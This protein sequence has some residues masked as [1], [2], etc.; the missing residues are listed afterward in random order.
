MKKNFFLLSLLTNQNEQNA[1]LE[2]TNL[3]KHPLFSNCSSRFVDLSFFLNACLRD[4]CADQSA[5]H[6]DEVKCSIVTALTHICAGK[7]FFID[8]L[9]D[10]TLAKSCRT[11]NYGECPSSSDATY[12][13]C[14]SE[15]RSSC[16]DFDVV[17]SSC[18]E[19]CLPGKENNDEFCPSFLLN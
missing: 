19:N 12:S 8:W 3:L 18:V 16:T 13:E 7:G 4:L 15:C 10:E 2:C 17:P 14:V 11:I 9:N 1:R 6:R 5:K